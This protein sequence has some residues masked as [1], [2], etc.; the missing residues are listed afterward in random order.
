MQTN[1]SLSYCWADSEMADD[2]YDYFKD[3]KDIELHRDTID[4][5]AWDS[6]KNYMQSLGNSDYVILLISDAY[7]KSENCMYEV[8]EVMRDR[9]YKEKIFPVV[10]NTEIYKPIFKAQYVKHW[11]D[12]FYNLKAVVSEIEV[13]NLGRLNEDLKRYQDIASNI[14]EFLDLVSGMNNPRLQEI[15]LKIEE[16]LKNAGILNVKQG[17]KQ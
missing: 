5:G 15:K 9:R 6:I 1:I 17:G 4:I 12:E 10:V 16:K 11:Q 2:I 7:L 3:K 8:L 14:A 13:Q